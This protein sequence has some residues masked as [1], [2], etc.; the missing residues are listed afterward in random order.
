MLKYIF[1]ILFCISIHSL[2]AKEKTDSFSGKLDMN[3]NSSSKE[4]ES[5]RCNQENGKDSDTFIVFDNKSSEVP[6][7]IPAIAENI[8]GDLIAVADYR[9]S[10]ADIGMVKD[11]KLDLR[12]RIY[13]HESNEWGGVKTLVS[14]KGE[15]PENI[16]FGD[17]CIV[18]DRNSRKVLVTSCSGNVSFPKG[19]HENHQGWAHFYSEDGGKTWSDYEDRGNQVFDILDKRSDGP[20]RAFFI[21]SGKILQSSSV[22]TG[23]FYRI[24]CAALV[25]ANDGKT[26][27]NYVFYSDDFGKNWN[28]LGEVDDCPIPFGGDEPKV[29]ELPDGSILISSRISGGRFFNIFRFDD[30]V[31]GRGKWGEMATS[32]ANVKGV[33]ASTN[34]CNGEVLSVPVKVNENGS[35][36]H[37]LLQSV[38]MNYNGL[39]ANVSINYKVLETVDEY[40]TPEAIAKDW[41]GKYEVSP[42][43]SAYST[44]VLDRNGDIAF[45]F[46]ENGYNGG[47]DIVFK[48][49]SI[50]DLTN[51]KY[52]FNPD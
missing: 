45:L 34:A 19:T 30:V 35:S 1:G 26:K 11:G 50:E 48:R 52:S 12:Y 22:K 3:V 24:Y 36:A 47:Y 13:D 32:D 42:N 17:P 20:I 18:A 51:G 43:S 29:E 44:M 41:D 25:K 39:R 46:E 15:G 31:N 40:S 33:V 14:S 23:D 38:P 8:D 2:Q 16:S 28:L 7:R 21:G 5:I 6:Y 4:E 9:Y 37:L 27:V 49:I 10:K